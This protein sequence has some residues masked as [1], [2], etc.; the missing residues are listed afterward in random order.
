M[1]GNFLKLV[2]REINRFINDKVMIA[3]AVVIPLIICVIF[4]VVYDNGAITELPIAV[5]DA[6][7]SSVSRML[8]RA[9]DASSSIK[10]VNHVNSIHEIEEGIRHGNY[11]GGIYFPAGMERDIKAN[12][13]TH[14]VLYKN[15]QNIIVCNYLLREGLSILRTYNAGVLLQK[16]RL[17]GISEQQAMAVVNPISVDVSVLYNSNF[18]YISFLSPGFIFVQFQMT[19]MLS[20]LLIFVRE[21]E[22]KTIDSALTIVRNNRFL[23]ILGKSLPLFLVHSL[24]AIFILCI[25]F[26]LGKIYLPGSYPVIIGVTILFILASFIPGLLLGAVIHDSFYATEFSI[27]INM[28]TFIFSGYT[29]PL[30]AVPGPLVA[31]SQIMPF[32]HFFTA[33]FKI[34][35]MNLP[36]IYAFPEVLKLLAFIII[37]IP[38]LFCVLNRKLPLQ[39]GGK[40]C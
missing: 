16:L 35:Q 29:F 17:K 21:F 30:W 3:L 14:P 39:S 10:I 5:Y 40:T 8:T 25:A 27:F 13:Q 32:T 1:I 4:I 7:N 15:S 6:D 36:M 26:P 33:F 11:Q 12:R 18:S 19:V 24:M 31:F 9:L 34:A 23:F 20:A 37:P 28:P 38:L 22:R 2:R